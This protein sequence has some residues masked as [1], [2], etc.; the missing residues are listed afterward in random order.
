[1]KMKDYFNY[2]QNVLGAKS[3]MLPPE[4]TPEMREEVQRHYHFAV[5]TLSEPARE[6]LTNII[7]ALKAQKYEVL[8]LKI[9]RADQSTKSAPGPAAEVRKTKSVLIIFGTEAAKFL[10]PNSQ[11][12]IG[13]VQLLAGNQTLLTHSIEA[14]RER[15]ELKREAWQHLKAFVNE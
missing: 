11:I 13:E 8:E 4:D 5:A 3:F 14:M 9:E 2:V 10:I 6:I 15:P 7:K 1:M 12:E